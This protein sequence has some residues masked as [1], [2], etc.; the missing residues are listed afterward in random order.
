MTTEQINLNGIET[1]KATAK[2]KAPSKTAIEKANREAA[3]KQAAEELQIQMNLRQEEV[4]RW[5][6]N[7]EYSPWPE[8]PQGKRKE[9]GEIKEY[10]QRIKRK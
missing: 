6:R 1:P 3:K 4:N 10:I 5:H 2:P 8:Y 9:N 7:N